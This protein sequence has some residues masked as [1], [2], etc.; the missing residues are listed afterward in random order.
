M[1]FTT[2]R[3]VLSEMVTYIYIYIYI[4]TPPEITYCTIIGLAALGNNTSLHPWCVNYATHAELL[5]TSVVDK[6]TIHIL[7]TDP[8][9]TGGSVRLSEGMEGYV[10]TCHSGRWYGVC[11]NPWY[12]QGAFVV[13]RELGYPATGLC[14]C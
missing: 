12:Y 5:A 4:H 14:T 7:F 8:S 11:S 1:D 2:R 9:C 10:E 13:C 6:C 3:V